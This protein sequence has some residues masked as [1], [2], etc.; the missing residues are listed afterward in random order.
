[1]TES[2]RE[3]DPEFLATYERTL[4]VSSRAAHACGPASMPIH[5]AVTRRPVSNDPWRKVDE[6]INRQPGQHDEIPI[7]R[8]F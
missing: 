8:V 7:E 5:S 2:V 6:G 4:L 3:L 1:M